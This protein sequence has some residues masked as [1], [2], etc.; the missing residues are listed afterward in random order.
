MIAN[1][2]KDAYGQANPDS[3]AADGFFERYG[4]D[5]NVRYFDGDRRRLT[6]MDALVA[7]LQSIGTLSE[8]A[9]KNKRTTQAIPVEGSAE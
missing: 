7:Y 9:S 5:A 8:A 4:V 1:A 2:E 6:E 3:G